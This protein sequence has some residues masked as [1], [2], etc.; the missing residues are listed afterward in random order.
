MEVKEIK[1]K[2]LLISDYEGLDP[3]RVFIEDLELGKGFITITCYGQSWA[4]YWGSMGE[5]TV[6]EFF[7]NCNTSYLLGCIAR[8]QNLSESEHNYITR[9]IKCVQDA[10]KQS[11]VPA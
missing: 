10:F 8:Y 6:K 5:R 2:S 4:C 9:I 1:V 3:V 11:E 7:I